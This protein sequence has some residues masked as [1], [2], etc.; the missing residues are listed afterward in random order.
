[1]AANS[2]IKIDTDTITAAATTA[3]TAATTAIAAAIATNAKTNNNAST[4][5]GT[6]A[7]AAT[8]APQQEEQHQLSAKELKQIAQHEAEVE[9]CKLI[10]QKTHP[11]S[12]VPSPFPIFLSDCYYRLTKRNFG[13]VSHPV[14]H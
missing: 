14:F 4:S 5:S 6:I 11:P 13:L 8:P 10:R 1:M 7:V 9:R 3:I 2:K 12:L